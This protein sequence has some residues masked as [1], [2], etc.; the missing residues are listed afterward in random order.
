MSACDHVKEVARYVGRTPD[1]VIVNT[2]KVPQHLLEKY[3]QAFQY[4][5]VDD[6]DECE[7]SVIRADLLSSE[8]VIKRKG[9][10][11]QR[12]LVRGDGDK[13]AALLLQLLV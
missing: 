4:P 1:C 6:C 12:S 7:Y 11:L 2:G 13:F 9:D 3:A 5:V 8:E 10:V